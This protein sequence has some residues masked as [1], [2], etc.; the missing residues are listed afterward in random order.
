VYGS[1]RE[2]AELFALTGMGC[3]VN[4]LQRSDGAAIASA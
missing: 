2:L 1:S 3:P 4:I